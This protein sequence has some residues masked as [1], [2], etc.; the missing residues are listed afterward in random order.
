M[1]AF[2]TP[3]GFDRFFNASAE[4]FAANEATPERLAQLGSQHGIQ[5]LST[6]F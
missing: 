4:V 2:T 1:I 5:F 6:E 3:G